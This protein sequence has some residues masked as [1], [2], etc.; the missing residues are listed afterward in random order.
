MEDERA[1]RNQQRRRGEGN[2][3]KDLIQVAEHSLLG[4]IGRAHE[5]KSDP[6]LEVVAIRAGSARHN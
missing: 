2:V 4:N 1:K 6:C 5:F 3:S